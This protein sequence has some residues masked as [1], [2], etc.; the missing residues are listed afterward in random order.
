MQGG[1]RE[2][3]RGGDRLRHLRPE[4]TGGCKWHSDFFGEW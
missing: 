4:H 1:G 3:P 2:P